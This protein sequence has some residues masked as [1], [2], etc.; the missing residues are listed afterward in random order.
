MATAD[1]HFA[2]EK[3]AFRYNLQTDIS[4][5]LDAR[6]NDDI[7][8]RRKVAMFERHFPPG[9]ITIQEIFDGTLSVPEE[10]CI[11][12]V[13]AILTRADRGQMETLTG[14][15][16]GYHIP[17]FTLAEANQIFKY[18]EE[19]PER[20][21]LEF[22]RELKKWFD[23]IIAASEGQMVWSKSE[24]NRRIHLETI[25]GNYLEIPPKVA[26]ITLKCSTWAHEMGLGRKD[27]PAALAWFTP[28]TRTG[29]P[30][31]PLKRYL[32]PSN[33]L[34]LLSRSFIHTTR[35]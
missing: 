4:K 8:Y 24:K 21:D 5:R 17:L 3:K 33:L 16:R 19:H 6:K 25:I 13:D 20:E 26:E 7:E 35:P 9:S 29:C 23:D 28:S 1:L 32:F 14:W 18:T 12:V 11:E 2:I 10:T 34:I 31:K 27:F 22:F 15:T 30:I